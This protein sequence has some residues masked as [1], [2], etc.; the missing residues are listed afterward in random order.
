MGK[1]LTTEEFKNSASEIHNNKYDYSKSIY[2]NAHEYITIICPKHGEFKQKAYSHLAG[3]GCPKCCTNNVFKGLKTFI[4]QAKEIHGDKYDYSKYEYVNAQTKSTIICPE[5]G[6]FYQASKEHIN[7]K[8][9]CPK[10]GRIKANNSERDTLED[11]INKAD[12]V[13]FYKY[14][15]SKVNYINNNTKVEII[16]PEHGSFWQT[17]GSHKSGRGCPMCKKSSGEQI[18]STLLDK[19]K[20]KY[21]TQYEIN[22]DKSINHCGKTLIDFYIPEY[23]TFIE[24]QGRQHYIPIEY[25]GGELK[26]NNYQIPRDNYIRTYCKENN[27]KLIEIKYDLT[28]DEIKDIIKNI[29]N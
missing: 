25:F 22:I 14:D 17:P 3:H 8:Q 19:Y 2:I 7:R 9:G 11:F 4:K 16:C 5:H 24:Y 27:I 21:L 23:N 15:Y 10:C 28:S 29:K 13:H 26:F 20:Y 1:K 6:E 12:S 18:I